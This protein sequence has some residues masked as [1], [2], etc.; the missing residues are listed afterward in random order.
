L[1]SL[2]IAIGIGMVINTLAQMRS[3]GIQGGFDFL[4]SSAGF[5]IGETL[6]SYDPGQPYWLAFTVGLLNTLRVSAIGILLATTIG[7]ATGL[8]RTSSIRL[9]QIVCS[10]YTELLRNI[11]LLLQLLLWYIGMIQL[12]PEAEEAITLGHW[13]VWS[14]DGLLLFNFSFSPE[15]SSLILGL[16]CY[17][18]A[19]IAEVV[20]SGIGAVST[21]QT[22]A[23]QSLGLQPLQTMFYVVL[24]QAM[25]VIVPPLTNQFLNLIKNSSLAVAIGY[26]DLVSISNTTLNQTGR[27]FECIAI[28][29]S[30]YL[31]LSLLTAWLMNRYNRHVNARI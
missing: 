14:K 20:R 24:P 27:A 9:L 31:S 10:G 6:I 22:Q 29:M 13:L 7:F 8:G 30:I 12:L 1:L 16:S 11:P 15:F 18:A 3:R 23:A 4:T 17:T 26:P 28:I 19:Y 2:L 21:G 5:D 25:K